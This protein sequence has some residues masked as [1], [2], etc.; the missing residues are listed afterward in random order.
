MVALLLKAYHVFPNR[1]HLL[2][3]TYGTIAC[4]ATRFSA[5]VSVCNTPDISNCGTQNSKL[6]AAACYQVSCDAVAGFL[7]EHERS[8]SGMK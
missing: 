3:F 4:I 6:E 1:L 8:V 7:R 2:P 5:A